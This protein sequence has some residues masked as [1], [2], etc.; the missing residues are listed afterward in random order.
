MKLP[1]F[2]TQSK[3]PLSFFITALA[4][5]AA[6]APVT[7]ST[8]LTPEDFE[9]TIGEGVWFIEYFSPYCPH[10]RHF[11]PTWTDVVDHFEKQADPGVRLAQVN[12]ALNGDLCSAKGVTGYP[13]MNLYRD[14][15]F[16]EMFKGNREFQLLVD[17]L[18]EHA[19]PKPTP[20]PEPEPVVGE[21]EPVVEPTPEPIATP[22]PEP[23]HVQTP[24]VDFNPAG[25]VAMLNA[26]T[27]D[28]FLADGPVFVKFFAPWCGHCKKL[29]PT[30]AQLARH[31]QHKMNIAE[32]DCDQHKQLC[33]SQGINGYPTLIFYAHGAKTEYGGSRKYDQ[34]IAFTEQASNPIMQTID[35]S[36]LEQV[37]S[38]KPVVY[39]L[40]HTST[41]DAVVSDVA[42]ESQFL[43][44]SPPVYVSSSQDLLRKYRIRADAPYAIIAFKDKDARDP[45]SIFYPPSAQPNLAL[46]EWLFANRLPTSLELSRD[47]FQQVMNAPNKPLVVI[48]STPKGMQGFV[49]ERLNDIG[50]KWRLKTNQ[51][52]GVAGR[53]DVVFTWMDAEQWAKWMKGMYG[54]KTSEEPQVVVADHGSLLYYDRDGSGQP[55]KMNFVSISSALEAIFKGAATAKHSENMLERFVKSL[56]SAIVGLESFVVAHPVVVVLCI[57]M[58]FVALFMAIRRIVQDDFDSPH[59]ERRYAKAG[60]ID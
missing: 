55:L 20:A 52:P 31:M 24:R 60:H 12:C 33:A 5:Q 47:V 42:K 48:V 18:V 59:P 22:E 34:L 13:Q 41:D 58:M 1:Q 29:A 53:R 23:L 11:A 25:E 40:L 27:F 28:R 16:V 7:A 26:Q 46:K 4:I 32:V 43:F 45:T 19:E 35:A 17:Y 36:Q 6:A 57:T 51:G 44:G 10:C 39:L 30:W 21:E 3:S 49:E 9:Q 37:V 2:L 14:G 8:V 54:I 15:E 50:R 56:N 38:E